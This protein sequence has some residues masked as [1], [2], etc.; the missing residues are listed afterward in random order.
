MKV[1]VDGDFFAEAIAKEREAR[2]MQDAVNMAEA[3][4][5][6]D[7]AVLETIEED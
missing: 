3:V 5:N 4:L 2:Y 1:A 6:V 7:V